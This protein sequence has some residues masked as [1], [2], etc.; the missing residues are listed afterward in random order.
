MSNGTSEVQAALDAV[1]KLADVVDYSEE[2]LATAALA[3]IPTPKGRDVIDL[4]PF[5]DKRRSA[6]ERIEGTAQ[7]TTLDAFVAHVNRFKDERTAIFA[8]DEPGSPSL[9]AVYDYH[10]GHGDP[11][12]GK[13]RA[14]YAFP[15]SD[16]WKAWSGLAGRWIEQG[17]LAMFLEDRIADVFPPEK[18]LGSERDR[19]SLAGIELGGPSALSGLARNL[20]VNVTSECTQAT[21]L[22]TGEG[23]LIFKETHTASVKVPS[24]FALV[25]PVFRGGVPETV[26]ARL[27]YRL[28]GGKVVFQVA[29]HDVDALFRRAF[30]EACLHV[31]EKTAVASGKLSLF[32]GSPE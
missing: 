29:L 24:G 1:E 17:A 9:L 21:T 27:R 10:R 6:P 5:R 18:L 25:I 13:H 32:F 16:P 4:K 19:A 20:Q 23:Q 28:A 14:V 31:E 3:V 11:R 2:E 30:G 7:L 12:F 26:F 15:L 8:S 22:A